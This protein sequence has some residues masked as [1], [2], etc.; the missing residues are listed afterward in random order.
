MIRV[1]IDMELN[2]LELAGPNIH[3]ACRA[4][5]KH[6]TAVYK[7][8]K[9]RCILLCRMITPICWSLMPSLPATVVYLIQEWTMS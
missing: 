4:R 2:D 9:G 8:E 7:S 3:C 6:A 5:N 1:K